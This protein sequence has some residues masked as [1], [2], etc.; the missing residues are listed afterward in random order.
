MKVPQ[1]PPNFED[2]LGRL[3][4]DPK[5]LSALLQ[6]SGTGISAQVQQG[7]YRHWDGIRRLKSPEGLSSEEWWVGIKL[8]RRA[9]ARPLPLRSSSNVTFKYVLT[10]DMLQYLRFVDLNCAGEIMVSEPV[11][12]DDSR[13]KRLLMNSVIEEATRSSQLEG[14]ST[15]RKDAKEM[16][17]TGRSPRDRSERMILNNYLAMEYIRTHSGEDLTPETIIELQRILTDGTLDNPA[18]SGTVQT[19][20]DVR[21]GVYHDPDGILV[22]QPPPANDLA[23][24][25]KAMCAFANTN[26]TDESSPYIHPAV[27]AIVLHLWLAYDHPFADGNG[28]TARALFYWSMKRD[29]YWLVEFLSISKI[30]RDGPTR[31]AKSFLYT[32]SDEFDATYFILNQLEV[33]QRAFAELKAY[34][35][36]K[37]EEIQRTEQL[38]GGSNHFNGRQIALIRHAIRNP[39]YDYTVRSHQR[40]HR[41][42]P[43]SARNDLAELVDSE[44]LE[45]QKRGK[46]FVYRSTS[47][48]S[49]RLK[50]YSLH[51]ED[52]AK[53]RP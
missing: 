48:L 10:D 38:V 8:A 7:K 49:E 13:R 47:D 41:I 15:T 39:G 26:A 1:T 4:T 3:L 23:K 28:R 9:S 21:V 14:A 43:Q 16:I 52:A 5:A 46:T 32:E 19:P 17:R 53:R 24:R 44:F 2:A 30:L 50:A 11:F 33:I 31:Y 22:H 20:S 6:K 27:K 42:S 18:E 37:M 35:Q 36:R 34:M 40:S 29:G 45:L 51:S 25:M 12:Q